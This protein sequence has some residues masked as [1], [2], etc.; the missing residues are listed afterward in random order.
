M[1]IIPARIASSRFPKKILTD[2]NG[3]PMFVATAKR[4]DNIDDVVV[5]TD[6]LEVI[7]IA[8]QYNIQTIM[9]SESH[10]SGTDRVNEAIS[11]LS[12]DKNEIII[13]VQAD[14]PFIEHEIVNALRKKAKQVFKNENYAMVSCYKHITKEDAKNPNLVKVVL[15]ENNDALYFSRATIPFSRDNED[16]QYFGHLGLYA[17]SV[18]SLKEFCSH[19]SSILENIEKLE[20][21]RAI[22]SGKKIAMIEVKSNSIGIDTPEDLK[23]ALRTLK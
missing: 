10:N 6:S 12:L 17:Y 20:Q 7:E 21:L 19:P 22:E 5:A 3:V 23:K 8:K 15:D 9:T 1:I 18:A 14:E 2:I 4:V 16:V 13:N 11:K